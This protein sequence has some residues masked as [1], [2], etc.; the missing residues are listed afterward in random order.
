MSRRRSGLEVLP[1]RA[2][3]PGLLI[4]LALLF[5]V[6]LAAFRVA[7]PRVGVFRFARSVGGTPALS[8]ALSSRILALSIMLLGVLA[9]VSGLARGSRH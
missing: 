5:V 8:Y 4:V 2:A 1:A 3:R 9:D 7:M 6:S